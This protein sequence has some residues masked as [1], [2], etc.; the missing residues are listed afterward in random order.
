MSSSCFTTPDFGEV[1]ILDAALNFSDPHMV[2]I[3]YEI[4]SDADMDSQLPTSVCFPDLKYVPSGP[5]WWHPSAARPQAPSTPIPPLIRDVNINETDVVALLGALPDSTPF[6]TA[7]KTLLGAT[8]ALWNARC[9]SGSLTHNFIAEH[10]LDTAIASTFDSFTPTAVS[11]AQLP[12]EIPPTPRFSDP[13]LPSPLPDDEDTPMGGPG[14]PDRESHLPTLMPRPLEKGKW[15]P[16]NTLEIARRPPVNPSPLPAPLQPVTEVDSPAVAA[17]CVRHESQPLGEGAR[18]SNLGRPGMPPPHSGGLTDS[19]LVE[20]GRL[21]AKGGKTKGKGSGQTFAQAASKA[22]LKPVGVELPKKQTKITDSFPPQST[23]PP[24]RPSI[25]LSLMHHTLTSTLKAAA[26]SVLAPAL[27][28]VSNA[29]LTTTPQYTHV[30]VSAAKW[31]PKGNLVVFAGPGVSRDALYSAAHIINSAVSE[32]LPEDPHISARL[33]VKWGKVLINSVPTSVVEGHPTVHSPA[34]CWQVLLDN[35]PSLFCHLKVCQLP[36]W[37]R[38][39]SLF[40]LGSSLS[41]VFSFEDPDGTIAPT[42][43]KACNVYAF[44]AQCHVK[45][46]KNPPPSPA[47]R[48]EQ[49]FAERAHAAHASASRQGLQSASS[50][51][52]SVAQFAALKGTVNALTSEDKTKPSAASSSKRS[53]PR[54][55]P[56]SSGPDAPLSK[57]AKKRWNARLCSNMLDTPDPMT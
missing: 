44:R 51:P 20:T 24:M 46:W 53:L 36:S 37:V 34:M 56:P 41:L 39:P 12:V 33:N 25:V 3:N 10:S 14:S 27:V 52:V 26:A 29:A 6:P 4:M 55:L 49:G 48:Q 31:T 57:S 45:R 23:P 15:K 43:L 13:L 28:E 9:T 35:N 22:A 17:T 7:F 19:A 1:F 30:R 47:K 5:G 16:R 11:P 32:A 38:R 8:M 42:L 18:P 40:Q 21:R 50:M 54:S 2:C